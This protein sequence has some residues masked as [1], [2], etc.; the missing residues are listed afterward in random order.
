[1]TGTDAYYGVSRYDQFAE[2]D[3]V[4]MDDDSPKIRGVP[5]IVVGEGELPA[6][7]GTNER[8][9]RI[10]GG[11]KVR[12]PIILFEGHFELFVEGGG[13]LSYYQADAIGTPYEIE[14]TAGVGGRLLIG[15][16]WSIEIAGRAPVVG[17]PGPASAIP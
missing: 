7:Y 10:S 17:F 4:L 9:Q 8:F 6:E 1:M 16:G 2:V 12:Y 11:M 15:K 5:F 14:V 3:F 13:M